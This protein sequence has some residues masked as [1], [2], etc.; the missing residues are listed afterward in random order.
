MQ[1][2]EASAAVCIELHDVAPATWPECQAIL[3]MLDAAG[4]SRITLL[5]VP[6]FHR[7]RT[8]DSDASFARR[9]DARLARGDELVLHGYSHLD[10]APPPRSPR[11]F[12]TRR[13]LTRAEGEFAAIDEA[14]AAERLDRGLA[15]FAAQGWPVYGFVPPA[16]LLSKPAR[17]ALARSAH[18]F[19][20]VA[21][22]GGVFRLPQ[23][24]YAR[25]A[26]LCYSP[27]K[28]W[29]RALSRTLIRAEL[30][31]ARTMSCLRLAIHP[32]DA[33]VP[34]VMAHWRALV[35]DALSSRAPS[36]PRDAARL[37]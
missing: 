3:D 33:R 4:A 13:M 8:I 10:E 9:L 22:R 27:D 17:A 24:R 30:R 16:W 20:Y 32:Q 7:G 28:P 19:E 29:R 23:W 6:H 21:L 37:M 2:P 26:T 14:R 11:G 34:Q 36:T 35:E 31:R 12:V 5:V 25:S 1:P 18:R 15:L